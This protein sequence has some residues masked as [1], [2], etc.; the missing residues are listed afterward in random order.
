M[1]RHPLLLLLNCLTVALVALLSGCRGFQGGSSAG[2][3][4]GGLPSRETVATVPLGQIAGSP[5]LTTAALSTPNPYEG[6]A[7]A[8]QQGKDLYLKMNCAN[9]HAYTG[10]GNMGPDLTDTYWR[11]GGLPIQIYQTLVQGRPQGMPAWGE[12]LPP[13]DIWKLVAFIQSLGGT[14]SVKDY[15]SARQGDRPGE[16]TAPE[17]QSEAQQAPST[18]NVPTGQP[19]RKAGE[20]QR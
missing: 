12:A 13:E 11:Y 18:P 9:C 17:A 6:N 1:T 4:T 20:S 14:V 7:Q 5:T 16:T 15:L 8:I 3:P 19:A 10:K 2:T